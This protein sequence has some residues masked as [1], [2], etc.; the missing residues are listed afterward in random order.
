MNSCYTL[1]MEDLQRRLKELKDR[2]QKISRSF[3]REALR[4]QI[5]ELEAQTMKEGFWNDQN[6]ARKVSQDLADKQKRLD[7]L[8]NL[9]KQISDAIELANEQSSLQ[10]VPPEAQN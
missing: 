4:G 1:R 2:F 6:Q 9:E 10:G 3:D 5:H 8:E 7:I